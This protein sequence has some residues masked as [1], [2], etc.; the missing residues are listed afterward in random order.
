MR[1]RGLPPLLLLLCAGVP[2]RAEYVVLR[3]GQRLAV[4]AYERRGETY[5]LQITGGFVEVPAREVVTIEP[6]E[7]FSPAP[8]ASAQK[9]PYHDLILATA[10]K[11]GVDADLITSVIAVESNFE[12]RAISR[13]NARGLMQLLPD[14]AARLGVKNIFDPQENIAAGTRYLRELLDR[15]SNNLVL[16]LAAY[17]AGPERVN[18]FGNVPPFSETRSYV[19]RIQRSYYE[20]KAQRHGP[21]R[22]GPALSTDKNS[23]RGDRP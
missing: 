10:Q 23:A 13:K 9:I 20:R 17:N 7:V 1:L 2:L 19:R 14:T 11:Y 18:H 12:P 16:V 15:Y 21:Q 22:S 3:N 8:A 6:Q 4:N 5:R